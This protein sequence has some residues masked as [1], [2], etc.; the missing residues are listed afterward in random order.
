MVVEHNNDVIKKSDWIIDLGPEGGDRGG[1]IIGEGTVGDII[2]M[3][4]LRLERHWQRV[5]NALV[6]ALYWINKCYKHR[7][8]AEAKLRLIH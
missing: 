6:K 3:N 4:S 8:I 5:N 1:Y 2:K 7:D